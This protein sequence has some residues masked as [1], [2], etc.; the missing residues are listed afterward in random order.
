[1]TRQLIPAPCPECG[2]EQETDAIH[3]GEIFRSATCSECGEWFII[4]D[5]R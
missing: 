2:Y 4:Y 1:M 5:D 3:E